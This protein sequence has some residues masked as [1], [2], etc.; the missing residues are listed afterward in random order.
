MALDA[1]RGVTPASFTD[2]YAEVG[3]LRDKGD[4]EGG[5][6]HLRQ[7]VKTFPLHKGVVYLVLAQNLAREGRPKEA[8]D[9]LQEAFAT[10]C[11]Y[12]A[13]WLTGDPHLESLLKD[14][15]FIKVV[16]KLDERYAT[17]A[18]AARSDLLTRAPKD[19]PPATG[20][21]LL[22]A[23]H[24]NNSNARETA[25]YWSTATA[26][27]WVVAIPQSSEI[28]SSPES[29]TW[30]DRARTRTEVE[31]HIVRVKEL[32]RIDDKRIVIAGFSMGGLQAIALALSLG[33]TVRGMLPVAAWLP[34]AKE[35]KDL[36]EAGASRTMRAFIVCGDK[37]PSIDGAVALAGL[38]QKHGGATKLETHKGV[39]HEYPAAMEATLSRALAFM[40]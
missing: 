25:R 9:A 33:S 15:R 2:L 30:N 16:K 38:L 20:R 7:N 36:V 24:G 34:D 14:Q 37:D 27:G 40:R 6:A 19:E 26:D 11:R 29:F 5:I 32:H 12:K 17:D 23:L 3:R 31:A 8:L 10:G 18:K 39:G 13:Q 35:I 1:R 4:V 28:G 22:V 21:P